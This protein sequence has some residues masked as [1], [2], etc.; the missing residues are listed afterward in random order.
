[1]KKLLLLFG[2]VMAGSLASSAVTFNVKVPEGTQ[3][4]FVCGDFNG[5]NETEAPELQKN[6]TNTFTL[7]LDD[8]AS[9]SGGF[10]YL[11]G[12]DW[13]YVEKDANG[14]EIDNR[15]VAGN[16]DIVESWRSVPEYGVESIELTINGVKRL[17]KVYLPD[18]YD[19]STDSYPVIY[20]NTTQQ[21]YQKSGDDGYAG[22]Y[23][24]G[25]NSWNA[26]SRMEDLRDASNP[27]YVMVQVSSFLG[28]NTPDAH[29]D[30]IGTGE[31][32][33][34]L[35][36]FT[37]DLMLYV[38][39][40]WRVK[41]GPE[42][43]VI[44]GANY[45]ALF[46]LYAAMSR[47]DLFGTCVAMSPML[48][49]NPTSFS[50]LVSNDNKS[51]TYYISAGEKEP[52]W[53]RFAAGEL[54]Q[55][56]DNTGVK[57]Y[58]TVYPGASHNDASWG[59]GFAEVLKAIPTGEEPKGGLTDEGDDETDFASRIYTL[60]SS[61]DASY[62]PTNVKGQFVYT[63]DYRRSGSD[64]PE[65]ALVFTQEIDAKYKSSYYWRIGIGENGQD[66]WLNDMG[67]IGFSS[68]RSQPAWQN[69]AIFPDGKVYNVAAVNNGFT[70]QG[71]AGKIKMTPAGD[72]TS[73]ATVSFSGSD[74]GFTIH[75]GSVNSG[76]D[77]GAL[78]PTIYVDDNCTEAE[79]T[80]NF[81]LNK[82][83][84]VATST[85]TVNPEPE[86]P[87]FPTR[88]Y[89]LYAGD[90]Q[91]KLS[92]VG[93]FAYT[94]DYRR[95]GSDEP[96]E[97]MVITHNVDA[98]YKSKYYWNISTDDG[99]GQRWLLASPKDIGFSSSHSVVSWLNVA[100][101]ED[102]SV[103]NIAAHSAGF[104]VVNGTNKY[105]MK[106]STGYV[107]TA[108]VPFLTSDK[109]FAV[110][111]GSVNSASD[112]GAVTP[113]F[114]V[115]KDCLEAQIS[116]DFNLNKATFVETKH[117]DVTT[118][119]HIVSMTAVPAVAKAGQTVK[120]AV[121]VSDNSALNISCKRDLS[122]N[123]AVNPLRD[124]NVYTFEIAN[125]TEGMYTVNAAL[126]DGSASGEINVRV[127]SAASQGE[128]K[129][130]VN[131]YEGI[132]WATTG[133]YKGNFHTHT[134]QSFDTQLSTT[135]VVDR[136]RNAD[137]KILGLTDHDFNAYPWTMFDLYNPEAEPRD[138]QELGMLA[139]PGNE[140]SKDR[141]NN[142]S[143]S[144]GGEFNHHNDF[145]TGR[146]GQEFMS[147]RESY[148]Y[149]NAIGGLQIINHPG[150][151]WSLDNNYSAGQKNSPEWHADNF[152]LY[153]SL[154]GLEVY[155]QGNRRPNDRILWDQILTL[156][157]PGRPVWGYSCDDSHNND[158]HFR[159][160]QFMLMPSL[161]VDALKDAMK[162]G[163][164]VFSYEYTG[165][166]Q[167]KAP[168]INEITVDED[169]HLIVIDTDDA[170]TIEWIY[171]THRTGSTP[172]TTRS[173][174]VGT[175][176]TFDYTD[177]QGSYVRARLVNQYGETATQP[178][179]FTLDSSTSA[180]TPI[181][182]SVM[183]HGMELSNNAAMRLVTVKATEPV[184]RITVINA[185]GAIVKYVE[186]TGEN[187]VTFS[188]AELASGVYIVVVATDYAAYTGKFVR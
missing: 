165:S 54:A 40:N 78:T 180:E 120:V 83:S 167:A 77:M 58:F 39:S 23:F 100:I 109:S 14:D 48:W 61:S 18:G 188:T 94:T 64:T 121:T 53:M 59:E 89:T 49:I 155:N 122:Q 33:H 115:G 162:A 135:T 8:V 130:T 2:A 134:S 79:I 163:S 55:A 154:I 172:S 116:Y 1:M 51:Q 6:G 160:Y 147:L 101:Y 129:M 15:T 106:P 75:Y 151:Y 93:T 44:V 73:K 125:T 84:Y 92:P 143:E 96:V 131:A 149:T 32:S 177:Y 99:Q 171:S 145:F 173:T 50:G 108:T 35:N 85:G 126:A 30:Y 43:T 158:Q 66:G 176:N 24:F 47:P 161:T 52:Q 148:A 68:S 38:E 156:T 69:T 104:R 166:G 150:Q 80:Y 36:S 95:K 137:Y 57:A 110:N 185:A 111:F 169:N 146:Q 159:N 72:F 91:D 63:T 71:A 175:G 152:T 113:T 45:G 20:Y 133:R 27:G 25:A 26:H 7:T 65:P 168:R 21:R 87:A 178:F 138:P 16:P 132:N 60:H 107:S 153:P 124:G 141:R 174:I 82:V 62:L 37:T 67:T 98:S 117:G 41:K 70:V 164:T 187:T 76:S 46:S 105:D 90:Q 11:C 144:T 97:A 142:W 114:T 13:L 102:E 118:L 128:P 10:K 139:I 56:I 136:Y 22:D 31:A 42:S 29:V 88:T 179:G 127:L 74:K 181:A 9:V 140:L 186:G 5:W 28:E 34:F 103:D 119:P 123:V 81:A 4:C 19:E 157:M 112:Q 184:E 86:K 182:E 170:D 183:A 12:R 17:V 3:K